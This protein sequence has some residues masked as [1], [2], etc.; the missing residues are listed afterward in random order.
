[1]PSFD[2]NIKDVDFL[3]LMAA[4]ELFV[5]VCVFSF[6]HCYVSLQFLFE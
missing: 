1:M 6:F 2:D 5:C 3:C 4:C